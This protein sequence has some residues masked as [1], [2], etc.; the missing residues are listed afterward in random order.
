MFVPMVVEQNGRGDRAF[1]IYSRLLRDRIVFLGTEIDDQ[2]ANVVVSQLLLLAAEDPEKDVQLYINSPGGLSYAGMAIYD[3]IQYIEP[4]VSTI[5]VGMGMSAAAMVLAGGAK[6]KRL[7]L[8]SARVMIHQ[9]SAGMRGAP[10]DME[11]QLRETLAIT[12]RMTRILAHHTGQTYERVKKDIDRD[13]FMTAE[14][15]REYGLIDAVIEPRRGLPLLQEL[16][17]KAG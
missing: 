14:E 8:P 10:S 13:Y 15:A 16:A 5:C 1:D 3:A 6:G 9:G 2:V 12:D 17:G 4:E 7:A 11:I